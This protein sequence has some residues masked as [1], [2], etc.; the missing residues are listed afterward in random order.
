MVVS[1]IDF[2]WVLVW[3]VT[4]LRADVTSSLVWV[5]TVFIVEVDSTVAAFNCSVTFMLEFCKAV[6]VEPAVDRNNSLTS[7]PTISMALKVDS[8][9]VFNCSLDVEDAELTAEVT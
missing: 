4:F 8:V 5:P 7:V 9:S 1:V 6:T 3:L 2:N